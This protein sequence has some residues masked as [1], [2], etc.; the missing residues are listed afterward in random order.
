MALYVIADLHLPLGIDKPMDVFGGVWDNYVE[1]LKEN[2]QSTVTKDDV[3]II[4]GDVSWAT[5]LEEA[6]RDFEF[7]HSLNGK[8]IIIKG[9]HDYWWTTMNKLKSFVEENGFNSIEFLQNNY[10]MYENIALCGTRGWKHPAWE[11]FNEEDKKLF[12]RE[13][14]RLELSLQSIGECDDIF[15][16]SHYPP[17]SEQKEDNKFRQLMKQYGVSKCFYGH[18]HSAAQ[19]NAVNETVNGVE[20]RLIAADYLRFMPYRVI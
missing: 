2:W 1:R 11:N 15:V 14:V 4:A 13:C 16:F 17:I 5:Y 19:C 12:D 20:Y 10:Y 18:L 3:V 7:L 8:K 9:N 6:K